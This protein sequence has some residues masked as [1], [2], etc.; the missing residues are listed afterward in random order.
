MNVYLRYI[1][2]LYL[3]IISLIPLGYMYE[4]ADR[5]RAAFAKSGAVAS[6]FVSIVIAA[7]FVLIDVLVLTTIARIMKEGEPNA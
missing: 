1:L 3:V 2:F 7:A 4:V 5:L 6:T